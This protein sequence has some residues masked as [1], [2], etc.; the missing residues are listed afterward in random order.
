MSTDDLSRWQDNIARVQKQLT[1]LRRGASPEV[2]EAIDRFEEW[3]ADTQAKG[4]SFRRLIY[5]NVRALLERDADLDEV[6][7]LVRLVGK[8]QADQ[9]K[10]VEAASTEAEALLQA[11]QK[12]MTLH[13]YLEADSAA[14]WLAR[15][16]KDTE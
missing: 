3:L 4:A 1:E 12:G 5:T 16:S 6:E 2:Q 15:P 9:P 11:I 8:V 7:A 14:S 13:E 10:H